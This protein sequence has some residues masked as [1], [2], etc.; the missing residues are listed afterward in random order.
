M[1]GGPCQPDSLP[2]L[3]TFRRLPC[4]EHRLRSLT[5]EPQGTNGRPGRRGGGARPSRHPRRRLAAARG[6]VAAGGA[7]GKEPDSSARRT[8]A[9]AAV[10]V[11]AVAA[12]PGPRIPALGPPKADAHPTPTGPPPC[13]ASGSCCSPRWG[14]RVRSGSR[15][16]CAAAWPAAPRAGLW[17]RLGESASQRGSPGGGRRE[18]AKGNCVGKRSA[19]RFLR[20]RRALRG[21]SE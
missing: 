17:A 5:W 19:G 10:A 1:Q 7:R 2:I 15:A 3:L 9:G 11:P 8:S 18:P 21:S 6:L 14:C 4:A 12:L 13:A 16:A 20:W